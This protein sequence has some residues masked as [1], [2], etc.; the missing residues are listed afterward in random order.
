[1]SRGDRKF[2]P[3]FSVWWID[4]WAEGEDGW[5]WNDKHKLF[6]FRSDAKDIKRVF[7]KKL[8]AHLA[9]GVPTIA[10]Y[11]QHIDL[12]RGW[13]Y[14]DEGWYC[15]ELRKKCNDEPKYACIRE[16]SM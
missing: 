15:L 4:A 14:V 3:L 12:G 10:G 7:L 9:N 6:E 1:M 11:K 13:Y 16:M 8:R 5:T 2:A